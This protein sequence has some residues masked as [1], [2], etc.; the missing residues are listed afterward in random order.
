MFRVTI[1]CAT[2]VAATVARREIARSLIDAT[3]RSTPF[4]PKASGA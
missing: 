4:T 3:A 2:A 1:A